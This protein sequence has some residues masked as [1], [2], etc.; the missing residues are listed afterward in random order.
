MAQ[1][2]G[3]GKSIQQIDNGVSILSSAPPA[4]TTNWGRSPEVADESNRA[5]FEDSGQDAASGHDTLCCYLKGDAET[6]MT[7]GPKHLAR[8]P[9]EPEDETLE[10]D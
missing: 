4:T 8:H 10:P 1:F 3:S 6:I 7:P 9:G 5:D 2:F